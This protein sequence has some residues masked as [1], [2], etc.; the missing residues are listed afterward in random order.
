VWG[1]QLFSGYSGTR[2]NSVSLPDSLIYV[3]HQC[4]WCWRGAGGISTKKLRSERARRLSDGLATLQENAFD[5]LNSK[6]GPLAC[7]L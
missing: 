4:L 5:A 2:L 1:E 3:Y 7:S 6:A